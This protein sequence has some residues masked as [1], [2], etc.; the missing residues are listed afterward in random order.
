MFEDKNNLSE[1]QV[2][3][4]PTA[5]AAD[6]D[7]ALENHI[8]DPENITN[9]SEESKTVVTTA[10]GKKKKKVAP[11]LRGGRGQAHVN[12]TYNNTLISITDLNGAVLLW[13]TAGRSGFKGPKKSTPYAAG[14]IVKNLADKV[15]ALGIKEL[16]VYAKGVGIGREAAVRAFDTNGNKIISIT[17]V[18]PVAHGGCRPRKRRRV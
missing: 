4:T 13:S 5:E 2:L 1:N 12:S 7:M 6:L 16:D 8:P 3:E 17:D 15:K 9:E 10:K 18:T 11:F 14:I